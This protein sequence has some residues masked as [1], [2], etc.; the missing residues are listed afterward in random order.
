MFN[1]V[2]FSEKIVK[3]RGQTSGLRRSSTQQLVKHFCMFCS[4]SHTMYETMRHRYQSK[5]QKQTNAHMLTCHLI[6]VNLQT[7]CLYNYCLNQCQKALN[8][9]LGVSFCS[10]GDVALDLSLVYAI[11]GQPNQ[12]AP[13]R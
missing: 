13:K 3:I 4:A 12:C 6:K 2:H 5:Y 1:H 8:S 7:T 9:P 10:A 11:H